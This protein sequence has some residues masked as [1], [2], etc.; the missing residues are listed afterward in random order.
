M[1]ERGALEGDGMGLTDRL[2]DLKTKATD[3]AVEHNEKI[4]EAVEKAA[5]TADQ[6]T[7]GKYREQI[8]KAGAK[9]DGFVDS[10][11]EDDGSPAGEQP[12]GAAGS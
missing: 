3:A 9:A 4:H 7:G 12:G 1:A 5:T 6:R 10:L 8:Q 2:K 11:K